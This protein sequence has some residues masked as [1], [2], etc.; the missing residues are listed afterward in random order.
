MAQRHTDPDRRG[1]SG[2]G[3]AI[4]G[5]FWTVA[6]AVIAGYA[7][8]AVVGAFSLT[9]AVA[10]TFLVG[11]LALLWIVHAVIE[12]RHHDAAQRDPRMRAAR[13]RRGF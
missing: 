4:R 13:Q 10:A 8:F 6:I 3:E 11:A 12:R 1:R 9:D 7:F 2:P 5:A